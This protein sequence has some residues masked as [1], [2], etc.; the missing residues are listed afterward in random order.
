MKILILGAGGTGGYFGGRL[1]EAGRDVTFLVREKRA[2][3]LAAQGLIVEH[4]GERF[5]VPARTVLASTVKP[6]YDAVILSCKAYDLDD[7]IATLRPALGDA[8]AIVPLLN[9]MT[10][11]DTLDAAFGP[12][13]V[14][15]GLCQ[16][17][18]TLT[19]DGVVKSMMDA[20][21][22]AWGARM[23]SQKA[24][25]DELGRA[26]D[27]TR[28]DWRVSD[29]IIGEMWEKVAFLATLASMTCLMRGSVGDILAA[30]GGAELLQRTFNA[31]ASIAEK[32]GHPISEAFR[33]RATRILATPGAPLT[34]S[35]LRDLESGGRVEADPIVGFMLGKA[36]EFGLDDGPLSI[37]YTH[38]KAY[39][40]R[41]ARESLPIQQAKP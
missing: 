11:L 3:Q 9:G 26:F 30:P 32:A 20:H 31:N 18:G 4:K 6:D 1:I 7:A 29:N 33:T 39:E 34:A 2:A 16:I 23:P 15:G 25:A 14:L 17:A 5:T 37:A 41:R 22:I 40:S 12:A 19:P 28:A 13:R 36:R 24:V 8:T 35:M 10:H 38:L 21:L 27:G